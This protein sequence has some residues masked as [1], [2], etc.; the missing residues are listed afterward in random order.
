MSLSFLVALAVAYGLPAGDVGEPPRFIA[1]AVA[2]L[3]GVSVVTLL[4]RW[5]TYSTIERMRLSPPASTSPYSRYAVLRRFH[6]FVSLGVFILILEPIGWNSLVR[7]HGAWDGWIFVDELLLLTPY[8][9]A[10]SLSILSFYRVDQEVLR[11]GAR[12]RRARPSHS[13]LGYLDFQ[14]RN[15]FGVLLLTSLFA[16]GLYDLG[17]LILPRSWLEHP[18]L[19]ILGTSLIALS[20][21]IASPLILRV[22]WRAIPLPDGSLRRELETFA[23]QVGFRFA[24]ILVWRTRGGIANAAVTGMVPQLRYVL[25][26][27][28]LLDHLSTEELEGVFGHEVG[29]IRHHHLA[30]YCFFVIA[31]ILFISMLVPWLDLMTRVALGDARWYELQQWGWRAGVEL[32]VL[33]PY[34][35]IVFGYLS[36]RFER[37][38]DVYGCRAV[39]ASLRRRANTPTPVMLLTPRGTNGHPAGSQSLAKQHAD[40]RQAETEKLDAVPVHPDGAEV[41]IQ[42]LENVANLNGVARTAWSWR[43]G[44]IAQRVRFLEEVASDPEL[45]DRDDHAVA[46]LRWTIATGLLVGMGTLAALD[47]LF[48]GGIAS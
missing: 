41:F 27:D 4:A 35:A 32:G 9:G 5:I 16:T 19:Q 47:Y 40:A 12:R 31:S 1:R 6:G 34:F 33:V 44:S 42:S 25:M 22:V 29:H 10:E 26:S 21:L 8:L 23:R 45:A 24:N 2:V 17:E 7:H 14:A 36:Q 13:Q 30:Y 39:S 46:R 3:V 38:A 11:S 28:A 15:Q 18:G 43:H 20:V 37:Q 48:V